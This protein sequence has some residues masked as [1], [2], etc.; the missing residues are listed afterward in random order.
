MPPWRGVTRPLLVVE[1][2]RSIVADR[3]EAT[4]GTARADGWSIVRGWAAP[5]TGERVVCTGAI[6]S[7]DDARRALLAALAGAGLV[8]HA[9]TD[10][11]TID[12]LV[13]ELRSI[14]PVRHEL[15]GVPAEAMQ[16]RSATRSMPRD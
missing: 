2:S 6:A 12:R 1:G 3:L 16:R 7:A 15:A 14:G 9:R 13:D 5:M 4:L 8:A 11:E 10:R